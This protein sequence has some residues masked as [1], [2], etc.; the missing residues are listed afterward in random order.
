MRVS[1]TQTTTVRAEATCYDAATG[2]DMPRSGELTETVRFETQRPGV[3]LF[4]TDGKGGLDLFQESADLEDGV[5]PVLARGSIERQSTLSENGQTVG[6]CNGRPAA[7]GC[8]SGSFD[9]WRLSL[10]GRGR[11]VAV[12]LGAD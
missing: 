6:G 10:F 3:V 1:G 2:E 7:S 8:G 9:S 4:K 11:K 5:R 12:G